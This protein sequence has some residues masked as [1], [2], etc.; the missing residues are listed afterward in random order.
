[1][2]FSKRKVGKGAKRR[3][4]ALL[5]KASEQFAR[6]PTNELVRVAHHRMAAIIRSRSGLWA[7]RTI[8]AEGEDF[9]S[10]LC[11]SI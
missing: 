2:G 7:R 8:L 9:F 3:A 4:H 1:M 6:F 5:A 10:S 11:Y